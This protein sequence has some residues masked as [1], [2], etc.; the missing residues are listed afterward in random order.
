MRKSQLVGLSLIYLVI[1]ISALYFGIRTFGKSFMKDFEE[2]YNAGSEIVD[3]SANAKTYDNYIEIYVT[4][5]N[6]F[7]VDAEEVTRDELL[8]AVNAII[9]E[10][11]DSFIDVYISPN[12]TSLHL[13]FLEESLSNLDYNYKIHIED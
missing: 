4:E 5:E 13:V 8:P 12:S 10:W 2:G 7:F 1:V 9:E 3:S 6:A 11:P